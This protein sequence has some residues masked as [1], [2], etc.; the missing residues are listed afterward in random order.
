M[1]LCC[2]ILNNK[3]LSVFLS[4]FYNDKNISILIEDK[5]VSGTGSFVASYFAFYYYISILDF[6]VLTFYFTP[7]HLE[8]SSGVSDCNLFFCSFVVY[9]FVV[10]KI[11]HTILYAS[12]LNVL[13]F[14]DCPF[15]I[16]LT[17]TIFFQNS[18]SCV[19]WFI[20]KVFF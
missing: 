7:R 18:S 11:A 15:L 3:I 10:E 2:L 1:N 8:S 5:T 4:F 12:R 14:C 20:K 19:W 16:K 17:E 13:Q 6:S 9:M